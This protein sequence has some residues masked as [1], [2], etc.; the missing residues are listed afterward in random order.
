MYISYSL[1]SLAYAQSYEKLDVGMFVI[2]EMTLQL[3]IGNGTI[4]NIICDFLLVFH[5]KITIFFQTSAVFNFPTKGD[6]VKISPQYLFTARNYQVVKKFDDMFSSFDIHV[7]HKCDRH[8][9][10]IAIA[11]TAQYC[12]K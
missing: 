8:T 1:L 5:S 12:K 6:L 11:H 10:R 4:S 3:T 7:V 9:V 2:S